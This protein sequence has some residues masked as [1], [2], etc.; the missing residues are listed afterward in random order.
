L[1][2]RI[3]SAFTVANTPDVGFLEKVYETAMA[4]EL[5]KARLMVRQQ[6]ATVRMGARRS[7]SLRVLRTNIWPPDILEAIAFAK[8]HPVHVMIRRTS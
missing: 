2:R 7:I 5:T 3:G 8:D 1:E 4:R 6:I